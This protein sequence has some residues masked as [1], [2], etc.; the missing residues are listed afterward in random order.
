MVSSLRDAH[1]YSDSGEPLHLERHEHEDGDA[2]VLVDEVYL[3]PPLPSCIV[4]HMVVACMQQPPP[5]ML[6][7][8]QGTKVVAAWSRSVQS[9][10]ATDP[11]VFV[12]MC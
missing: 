12:S 10:T 5:G 6:R 2:D 1:E 8:L 4:Q 7:L 11:G 3:M 9:K